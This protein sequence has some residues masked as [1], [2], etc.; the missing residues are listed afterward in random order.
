MFVRVNSVRILGVFLAALISLGGVGLPAAFSLPDSSELSSRLAVFPLRVSASKRYL[1]DSSGVPFLMM[2]D[3]PQA[4]IG[5]VS[6]AD[7]EFFMANRQKYG[8]NTLWVNLLCNG[9]TA[10]LADGSTFDGIK[11]F[12]TPGDLSTPNA[13]YFDRAAQMIDLAASHGM[14]VLLDPIE[15][16]GW[17][18]VLRSNQE[19][20]AYAYGQFLGTRFKNFTNIIWMSGNDF[21]THTDG[22]DSRLVLAVAHGI[23]SKAPSQLQTVELNYMVSSSLD[24]S[25]WRQ[26]INLDAVYTY[27]PTYAKLYSEYRRIYFK[28]TFMVEANYEFEHNGGTDGGSTQNLR[29]QEYWSALSGTTGQLY[30]SAHSWTLLSDWKTRLDTVGIQQFQYVR[31]L[32]VHRRWYNLVPDFKHQL[33]TAG[34]GTYSKD[35][36]ITTDTFATAAS[37]PDGKTALIYMPNTRTLTIDMSKM[38]GPVTA[39]WYDP[40]AGLFTDIPGNP[41]SNTGSRNFTPPGPNADGDGDWVLML[42][43]N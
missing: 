10:C 4:L 37:T 43:A 31:R 18:G 26:T 6:L 42:K 1:V 11:P 13:A 15:T 3:S 39:R 35:G 40:A 16:G 8:I 14:V 34:Y 2:G 17:L 28:P 27:S 38:S 12:L 22:T 5:N 21:Q 20:K 19:S 41:L 32:M 33:L 25:A 7:A 24:N 30:G 29:R 23:K 36:S 9:Y